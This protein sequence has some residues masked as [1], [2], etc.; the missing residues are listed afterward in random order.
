MDDARSLR[1]QRDEL[2]GKMNDILLRNDSIDDTESIELL[3]QGEATPCRNGHADSWCPRHGEK[4]VRSRQEA[5]FRFHAWCG[6][7]LLARIAGIG[8]R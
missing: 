4:D 5:V 1:E 2:A 7:P 6:H 3:E 8:S